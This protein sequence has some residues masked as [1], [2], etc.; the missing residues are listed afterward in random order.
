[1]FHSLAEKMSYV[2]ALIYVATIDHEGFKE[3]EKVY[4]EQIAKVY[5]IPEENIASLCDEVANAKD[6]ESILVGI[7]DRKHKL[8]LV[9]E[10]MAI[11]YADGQY[12][13][14]EKIGMIKICKILAIEES[15]LKE[16]ED[17]ML[18][19]IEFEKEARII[20]EMED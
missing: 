8:M 1:M 16:I 10:L 6:L 19:R 3:E 2:K 12:Q 9:N 14:E 17:L 11:C 18:R 7:D 13:E 4:I 15:K 20:L 5:G